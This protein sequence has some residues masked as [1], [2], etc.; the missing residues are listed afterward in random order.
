MSLARNNKRPRSLRTSPTSS[1]LI[2]TIAIVSIS[3]SV[4]FLTA[5]IAESKGSDA[6]LRI[7]TSPNALRVDRMKHPAAAAHSMSAAS[8]PSAPAFATITVDNTGD[9]AA[10]SACTGAPNDCSLRGATI[11]A[12]ANPGTTINLPAGTYN[13]TTDGSAEIGFCLDENI[14]DLNIAGNNTSIVGAGAA[15]TIIHQTTPND[16]VMCVDANLVGSFNFSISG[17]TISGGHETN[18]VGGGGIISGG[19]G[20]VTNVTDCIITGNATSGAGSPVGG[21]IGNGAGTLNVSG[22]TISN[23]TAGASGAGIFTDS[24]GVGS[25]SLSNSTLTGNSTTNGNGGGAVVAGG[26]SVT[27]SSFSSNHANGAGTGGGGLLNQGG[28]MTVTLSSFSGN[29]AGGFGGGIGNSGGSLTANYSRIAN[30][31]AASGSGLANL[32]GATI[33]NDNW[34]GCNSG[35]GGSCNSVSGTT[36]V[37]WLLLSNTA[38]SSS[39][40]AGQQTTLTADIKGRNSGP[41]LTVE[42][43][44][45]VPI[46]DSPATI[47]SNA[48]NGSLSGASTQFING[49][50]TATFT[51]GA[52][53]GAASAD[54]TLDS[55][56]V[57]ASMAVNTTTTSDPTD[58]TV[59]QG[60][61]ANFS[62]TQPERVFTTH[63]RRWIPV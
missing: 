23:N 37:G 53:P 59:C 28:S 4:L 63:G 12:N 47:F 42:L 54:A 58:Q 6:S 39:L 60:A 35:P 50:A 3:A 51:A 36:V 5:R 43:N 44:G 40:C 55:E 2:A 11:F 29:T 34:W 22:T 31:T 27:S 46:P 57:T 10:A 49:V 18:G 25:F 7:K 21:G 30:N 56:T 33:A 38:A 14:G 9:N 20:D 62:T 45:L 52:T 32:G 61:T 24:F 13:L 8:L 1:L 17:V 15:T 48:V 16:R 19:F 41:A 26:G